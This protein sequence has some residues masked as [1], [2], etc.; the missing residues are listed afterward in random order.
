M[1]HYNQETALHNFKNI[2]H[3][4]QKMRRFEPLIQHQFYSWF[5]NRFGVIIVCGKSAWRDYA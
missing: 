3:L 4:S 5:C 1:S 2:L